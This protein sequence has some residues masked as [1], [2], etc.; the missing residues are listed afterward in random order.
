MWNS[1]IKLERE[2]GFSGGDVHSPCTTSPA[3]MFL[4]EQREGRSRPV[5]TAVGPRGPGAR[6]GT[7][8]GCSAL[9]KA[10]WSLPDLLGPQ[11]THCNVLEKGENPL[12]QVTEE[13][14]LEAYGLIKS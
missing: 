4:G 3:S 9:D 7:V 12:G 2:Q 11:P 1:N 14:G 6:A 10:F 5:C 8:T 13:S